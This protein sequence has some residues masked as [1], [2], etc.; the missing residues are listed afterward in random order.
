MTL[1][2]VANVLHLSSKGVQISQA[3]MNEDERLSLTALE[4]MERG[5]IDLDRADVGATRCRLTSCVRKRR[6]EREQRNQ[7]S[8]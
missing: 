1:K 4:V 6:A 8:A 7:G 5:L 3:T 2:L